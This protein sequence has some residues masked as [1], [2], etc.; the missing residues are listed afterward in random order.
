MVATSAT[1][2][3]GADTAGNAARKDALETLSRL[4]SPNKDDDVNDRSLSLSEEEMLSKKERK[5]RRVTEEVG[6]AALKYHLDSRDEEDSSRVAVHDERPKKR[7]AVDIWVV[8]AASSRPAGQREHKR[9]SVS[10]H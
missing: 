4:V 10:P 9:V 7:A 8:R 6:R 5:I 3:G 1:L 2:A